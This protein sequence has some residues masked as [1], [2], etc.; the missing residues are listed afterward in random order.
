MMMKSFLQRKLGRLVF[1][2]AILA[3]AL[4]A[5]AAQQFPPIDI[6]DDFVTIGKLAATRKA[7][8]VLV[9]TRPECPYCTRAKREHLEPLR[10]SQ[11]YGAK[12]I[13][14]EIVAADARTALRDFDGNNTTHGDFARKY[15][16][17][18]VPTVLVVD[19]RGKPLA[20]PIIGLTSTDFYN[21]YLEQ[22]IDAGRL[23]L[24]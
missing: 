11:S 9:F 20:E 23:A 16:I 18:S 13:M 12:I 19:S 22:A 17:H 6:A 7:P 5:P 15:D 4:T 24:R 14:R 1:A 2:V 21:L 3:C 10:V 8:I